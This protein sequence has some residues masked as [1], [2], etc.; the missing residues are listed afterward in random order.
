MPSSFPPSA[1][2]FSAG[3]APSPSPDGALQDARGPAGCSGLSLGGH[4][5]EKEEALRQEPMVQEPGRL[6]GAWVRQK[7]RKVA[8]DKEKTLE[9]E[10]RGIMEGRRETK[11]T[12]SPAADVVP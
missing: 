5:P 8:A 9:E 6:E 7:N 12:A 4:Q 3:S 2:S 1:V 10:Y 11:I